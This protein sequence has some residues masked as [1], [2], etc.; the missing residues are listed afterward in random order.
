[1]GV[2][3]IVN[4]IFLYG[5]IKEF[6]WKLSWVLRHVWYEDGS[7]IIL[8]E[9]YLELVRFLFGIYVYLYVIVE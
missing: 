3:I 8:I 7:E 9:I 4:S 5:A 1:M 6:L 2:V